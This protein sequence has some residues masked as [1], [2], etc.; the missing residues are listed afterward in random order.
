METSSRKKLGKID[1]LIKENAP[2]WFQQMESHLRG[3]KQ[4]KV[5]REVIT[6]WGRE[7]AEAVAKAP[8]TTPL[9]GQATPEET[10]EPA[11][12]EALER[13][14]DNEDWNAKN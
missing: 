1:V 2:D 6:E 12:N 5:I 4:W 7:A 3:E 11:T 9:P 13:L 10:P 14:A 8:E